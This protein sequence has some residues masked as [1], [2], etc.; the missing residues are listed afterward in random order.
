MSAE[1]VFLLSKSWRRFFEVCGL[2]KCRKDSRAQ[3]PKGEEAEKAGRQNNP[4]S[5]NR[6]RP[7]IKSNQ[8][9]LST[10]IWLGGFERAPF[11]VA[12]AAARRLVAGRVPRARVLRARVVL[13]ALAAALIPP[14]T[15]P[16]V[17][18]FSHH[19]NSITLSIS[20]R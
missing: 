13:P 20:L 15:T 19:F 18:D 5:Q 11:A 3:G 16:T 8:D 10:V 14:A 7:S 9:S 4:N 12:L 6:L 2:R 1:I 17:C